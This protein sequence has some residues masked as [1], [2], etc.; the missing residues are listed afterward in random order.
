MTGSDE[1]FYLG[2]QNRFLVLAETVQQRQH[3]RHLHILGFIEKFF[4]GLSEEPRD[5]D[6]IFDIG[7]SGAA[8]LE[9]VKLLIGYSGGSRH[10]RHLEAGGRQVMNE[11]FA[12]LGHGNNIIHL[13]VSLSDGNKFHIGRLTRIG[14]CSNFAAMGKAEKDRFAK[15]DDTIAEIDRLIADI[16]KLAQERGWTERTACVNVFD[17]SRLIDGLRKHAGMIS[18]YR[19]KLDAFIAES[20]GA[21]R[22]RPAR[23]KAPPA[24]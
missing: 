3:V 21:G 1:P 12:K 14:R 15:S 13:P 5:F 23:K 8:L 7:R 6:R 18:T 19:G 22:K 11:R 20:K 24:A 10:L 4:Q 2:Y 9:F 17:N 16:R